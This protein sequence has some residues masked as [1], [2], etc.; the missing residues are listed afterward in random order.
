MKNFTFKSTCLVLTSLVISTTLFSQ[1]P[2]FSKVPN[3]HEGDSLNII[4]LLNNGVKVTD[5][6]VICWFPGDSLSETQINE[7]TNM[8]NAGI[9]GAEKFIDAPQLWQVHQPDQPYTFYFRL[10]RFVSHASGAGFISIP[11]W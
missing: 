4:Y 9:S 3:V 8:L 2:N 1:V 7:I 6:K 5:R 10:D 11:F